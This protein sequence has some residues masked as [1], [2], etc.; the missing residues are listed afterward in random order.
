MRSAEAGTR[1]ASSNFTFLAKNP[2]VAKLVWFFASLVLL[3]RLALLSVIPDHAIFLI[4]A[5][6]AWVKVPLAPFVPAKV[7]LNFVVRTRF[8]HFWAFDNGLDLFS[9][10]GLQYASE[11]RSSDRRRRLFLIAKWRPAIPISPDDV[12]QIAF[13]CLF[14]EAVFGAE[15][16]GR[17][18]V[19]LGV[20]GGEEFIGE[21][22]VDALHDVVC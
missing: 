11:R 7:P 18:L 3:K 12:G 22:A 15:R 9:P 16:C 8:P 4:A 13:D 5:V 19:E 14:I 2:R 17:C 1:A 6:L 10:I 20:A 21:E